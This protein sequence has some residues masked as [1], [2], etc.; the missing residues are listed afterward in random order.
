MPNNYVKST[1]PLWLKISFIAVALFAGPLRESNHKEYFPPQLS[2]GPL[3]E[4]RRF[5]MSVD[6]NCKRQRLS[7]GACKKDNVELL[8]AEYCVLNK[9]GEKMFPA[10]CCE[11]GGLTLVWPIPG[12]SLIR[13]SEWSK[14]A[15]GLRDML[16][17][18]IDRFG[19]NEGSE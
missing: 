4:E 15:P 5:S 8:V 11:C 17:K 3:S 7:C 18:G 10:K 2:R 13:L 14:L 9:D 1:Q 12:T 16:Q 19:F 6:A